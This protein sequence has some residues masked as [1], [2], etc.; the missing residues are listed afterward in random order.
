MSDPNAPRWSRLGNRFQDLQDVPEALR[1]VAEIELLLKLQRAS[2]Q[3]EFPK[4]RV[5]E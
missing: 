2:K 5:T 4:K 1:K 3:L